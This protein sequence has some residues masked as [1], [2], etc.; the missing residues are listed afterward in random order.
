MIQWNDKM[1]TGVSKIDQQHKKILEKFNEFSAV[2]ESATLDGERMI[3]AG[4]ILDFLQ[5]YAVWHFE[6]EEHCFHEHN[7][8]GA[9]ANAN[10]HKR[11]VTMFNSFYERWQAE[12]MEIELAT[13]T[14]DELAN[15]FVNHIMKIDTKLK[16]CVKN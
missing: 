8:P 16:P 4:K 1:E 2:L 12:G 15:W 13:E 6:K 11:F 14:F 7:C 10:A 9:L 3:K 5:F